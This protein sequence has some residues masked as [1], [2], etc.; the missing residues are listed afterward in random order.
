MFK[1]ITAEENEEYI[2]TGSINSAS[3]TGKDSGK[4]EPSDGGEG[5]IKE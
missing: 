4:V 3:S 5:N 2:R 1:D